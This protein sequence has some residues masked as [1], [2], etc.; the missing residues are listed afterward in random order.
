MKLNTIAF[1]LSL[2]A[3]LVFATEQL[4]IDTNEVKV[5]TMQKYKVNLEQLNEQE[6]SQVT[7]E[8]FQTSQIVNAISK[9]MESDVDLKVITKLYM[10]D[11]WAKKFMAQI[12]PKDDELKKLYAVQKPTKSSK[13]NLRNILVKDEATADKLIK[14]LSAIKDLPKIT[15]KFKEL[16]KSES[17]DPAAKT[18]EGEIGFVETNKLDQNMQALLNGKKGGD[19]V[20]LNIPQIGW[21]ILLIEEYEGEKTATFEESKSILI[22]TIRQEALKQEIEKLISQDQES[23]KK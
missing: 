17:I 10:V 3:S 18:S 12:N 20:K 1:S 22:A 13:Y 11:I 23:T 14:Q 16:A 4:N 9:Q 6:K 21:Q 15:A 2:F 7:N 5:Y 8:Y 19:L